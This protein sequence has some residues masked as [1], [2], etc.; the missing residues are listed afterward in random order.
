MVLEALKAEHGADSLGKGFR[1]RHRCDA[2]MGADAQKGS[3][4]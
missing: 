1:R 3:G 2:M 4:A